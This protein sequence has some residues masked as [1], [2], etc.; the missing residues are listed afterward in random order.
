MGEAAVRSCEALPARS[1][2]PPVKKPPPTAPPLSA[3]VAPPATSADPLSGLSALSKV[4]LTGKEMLKLR[5]EPV[6]WFWKGIFQHT[7]VVELAALSTSGKSTLCML[8]A[9]AAAGHEPI[10]LLGFEVTPVPEGK[11]VV[12]VNVE[13]T[14]SSMQR[15]L[16]AS[17][18]V[19]G[20]NPQAAIG[21]MIVVPRCNFSTDTPAWDDVVRLAERKAIGL[22]ILDSRARIF[23]SGDSNDEQHEAQGA[24]RLSKLVNTA[25]CPIVVVS[26]LRKA[27]GFGGRP[28]LED[29]SGSHQRAAG[30]DVVLA[31]QATRGEN[32]GVAASTLYCLKRRDEGDEQHPEPVRWAMGK[33]ENGAPLLT[34]GDG[35][36]GTPS[37]PNHLKM[38]ELLREQGATTKS[39]LAQALGVS[40]ATLNRML[41]V[42]F[43]EKLVK[44]V[45]R[46]IRGVERECIAARV[47]TEDVD[48]LAANRGEVRP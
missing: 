39:Q 21:R 17:C 33:D 25:A 9:V 13:Q 34:V 1:K 11:L 14:L 5:E 27:S 37:Q 24:E 16:L 36:T 23:R 47:T 46:L 44:R 32:G 10:E 35:A 28:T 43:A 20:R 38:V 26:H 4:A 6:R 48:R 45:K 22:L 40:G 2:P 42:A 8:L 7:D 30:P 18:A 29:V 19:L 31:L 41:T 15:K 12:L 3:P